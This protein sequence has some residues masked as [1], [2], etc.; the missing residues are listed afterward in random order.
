MVADDIRRFR[1]AEPFQPYKL[2]LANGEEL[3]VQR[4]GGIAIAPEGRYFVYP[5]DPG[6]ARILRP[7]EVTHVEPVGGTAA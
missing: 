5:L 4:R 6:G 3:V 1:E 2:V 7:A